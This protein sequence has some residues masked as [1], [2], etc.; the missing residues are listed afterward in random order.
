MNKKRLI[1]FMPTI[2][3]GGVEK[4]FI[5]ISN[6][7]SR[8]IDNISVVTTYFKKKKK[9]SKKIKFIIKKLLNIEMF[10]RKFKFFIGLLILFFELLKNK[11]SI[12]F[13]FQANI[14]CIY[15]CKLLNVKV[16]VR[17]NSSPTAWSNIWIK[18]IFL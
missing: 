1:M 14:Y 7:L 15:L 17:S 10:P 13:C 4:N 6:F 8:K 11:N 5:I 3:V 12:V 18:K 2:D 16:V 9:F